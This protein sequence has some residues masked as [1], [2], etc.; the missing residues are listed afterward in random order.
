M[1][2]DGEGLSDVDGYDCGGGP[3]IPGDKE[4]TIR[5][6]DDSGLLLMAGGGGV[7]AELSALR[8]AG[9]TILMSTHDL[10]G[11]P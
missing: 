10:A 9:R 4:A 3:S 5:Q 2:R 11:V 8:D 7:D 1:P 6:T